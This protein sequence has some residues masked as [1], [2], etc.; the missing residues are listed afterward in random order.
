[1]L[2]GT[3]VFMPEIAWHCSCGHLWTPSYF[4][5]L[6]WHCTQLDYQ[7]LLVPW[8]IPYENKPQNSS[9]KTTLQLHSKNTP[10][11]SPSTTKMLSFTLIVPHAI[12][13]CASE[14]GP[15]C[16]FQKIFVGTKY[17]DYAPAGIEPLQTLVWWVYQ[18]VGLHSD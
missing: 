13:P 18:I 17:T 8:R 7:L 1:M 14:R 16:P 4:R 10:L 3:E 5:L 12:L 15:R 11:L 6:E 2:S 9:E